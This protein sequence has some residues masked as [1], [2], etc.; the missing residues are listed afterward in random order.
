[1]EKQLGE[2]LLLPVLCLYKCL[3]GE[4]L[5]S[6]DQCVINCGVTLE[7]RCEQSDFRAL[8]L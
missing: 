6:C 2:K 3:G 4:L 7:N 8:H 5:H 1:M